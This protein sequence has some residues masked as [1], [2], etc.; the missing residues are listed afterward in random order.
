MFFPKTEKYFYSLLFRISL[1]NFLVIGIDRLDSSIEHA[2]YT[3][4]KCDIR[5]YDKLPDIKDINILIN[6]AGTQNEDDIN[7]NLKALIYITEK[8]GIQDNI[9][10]ILHL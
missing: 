2:N 1:N 10:S 9:K 3:H 4:Y 5:D 8:Y 6:N 7:I